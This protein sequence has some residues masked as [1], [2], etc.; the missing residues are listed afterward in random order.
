MA[1]QIDET[2]RQLLRL[3]QENA[4]YTAIELA[5]RIGVSDN[6]I[7][8]RMDRLED[9]G[10]ITGYKA[11]VDPGKANLDLFFHFICTTRISN[12]ADVAEQVMTYP[13]VLEVTELMT[14][15]ENLHIK[16][17]GSTDQDITN[18]AERLDDLPLEINDETLIRTN[19]TKPLDF[20]NL[21]N[22]HHK[23]S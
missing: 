1:Y 21:P 6:T 19:H 7:H 14:G 13:E 15:Q 2:D 9:A 23:D 20:T 12:R 18:M 5:E 3:L 10:I 4:R 16:M 8:N 22:T 17:V 11:T